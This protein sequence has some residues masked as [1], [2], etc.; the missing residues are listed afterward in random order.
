MSLA[1]AAQAEEK[2][3]ALLTDLGTTTIS[4]YID[5][6][7]IWAPGTGNGYIPGRVFDGGEGNFGGN[8][9]DGFNLNV[10]KLSIARPIGEESWPAGYGVDLLFGPD[11]YLYNTSANALETPG[12]FS[13]QQAY[14][15]LRAPVGRGVDFKLGTL[16]T[17]IGYEVFDSG[18]NPNYSRSFGLLLEPT[19]HTGLIASYAVSDSVALS[20]GVANTHLA[21]INLRS[22]RAESAKTYLGTVT[23]TAPRER[24]GFL[25]GATLTLGAVNGFSGNAG[26]NTTSLYAGAAL[27]APITGLTFGAAFDYRAD[28]ANSLAG[29]DNWAY[30]AAIYASMQTTAKLKFNLR[31]DYTSGSDGTFYDA[32]KAGVSDQG[33]ELGALTL[34]ADYSLWA[35]VV[36]RLETRW[37]HS[38]SSDAYDNGSEA[39]VVTLAANV[40][41]K[42]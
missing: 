28:G 6:S 35:N 20:G 26:K 5:T 1:T 4:G 33:N 15:A 7:A 22:P 21:Y 13:I 23:L 2:A 42:F 11:A 41:Y 17:I 10:V 12:D 30:A 27:P 3:S 18:S 31:A 19:Q 24:L 29:A 16:N 25:G 32:G 36:T 9:L 40:I 14:V 34:T 38:F 8:K 37:D 39:D